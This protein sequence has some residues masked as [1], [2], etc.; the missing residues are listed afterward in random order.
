MTGNGRLK[1][2]VPGGGSAAILTAD[3]IDVT[4]D[5][6]GLRNAGSMIGSAGVIVMDETVSIP[7][8]LL[9]VARFYAHESCGQC[10]PCRESTG[11]IYK[12]VHR[13][14]DGH[15]PQGG[16]RHHPRRGP[17]GAGTTICAFY[18]GAV[19]PY[20]SYIEKFR[21]EFEALIAALDD[22]QAHDRRQGDRGRGRAPTSS[23]RRGGSASRCPTT[24][25][26]PGCPSPGQCRLCMVDIEKAPRPTIA[27]N[28]QATDG[29]VVLTETE[30]VKRDAA[31]DHGVPPHQPSARLPGVR[32]GRGVLAADLLHEA[33]PLRP[34]DGR[35]EGPQAEGGAAR[36]PRHARCRALHPLLALRALL[37]RGH[38]HRRAR[39][40]PP[41]RSLGDRPVP[42]PRPR[43][44]VLGQRGRHLPGGRPHRPRLPLPGPRVVSRHRQVD[45]LRAARAAATSTSTST[46]AART[47]PRAGGWP[48]SSRA[49]TPTSTR[50]GCATRAATASAS[51]TTP[52]RLTV[53]RPAGPGRPGR[54]QLG[55]GGGGRRRRAAPL[56]ARA[57]RR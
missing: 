57:D 1:A 43:Q 17:R 56:C 21:A 48:G 5:V 20:I 30:R 52:S 22:A 19:G 53:P 8:A 6:D 39:H 29:M 4:M 45:L 10:T 13:I 54:R 36:A 24:A 35:R 12:M 2:V 11:W 55:R 38:R 3:E 49:S 37:R 7:E 51:S 47:T 46:A 25:T 23:R 33:R 42:G 50:G 31:V 34:A 16:S 41:G 15:G 28:T 9:V 18:D 27:C 26:T 44:Q 40:L 14:V 32:S